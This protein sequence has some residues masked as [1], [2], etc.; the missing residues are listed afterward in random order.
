MIRSVLDTAFFQD[1]DVQDEIFVLSKFR[2]VRYRKNQVIFNQ[3]S[4]SFEM[5]IVK[6]GSVKIYR[7]DENREIIFGHQF[8]GETIGE[9]EVIHYDNRRLASVATLEDT[10]LW[11][12]TK[13][14]LEELIKVYPFILR[15][16]FYVVS[17]R[18][19]QAD[20]KLEYLAFLDSRVRIAN[21]LLDLHSNF[22][23]ETSDGYLIN[24]KITRQHLAHMVGLNRESAT[25]VLQEMQNDGI[26]KLT[27]RLIT[28]VDM[29]SL[30]KLSGNYHDSTELREWHSTHKYDI[31]NM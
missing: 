14:D 9:L 15:K 2:E 13:T 1:I 20:R 11:A 26:I 19:Q 6:S 18:L 30:Q 4:P 25:R 8:P 10:V 29:P 12:I 31:P 5:Y 7:E 24:W 3:G 17:E 21:L 27:D 22:G 23:I 28:I 16:L